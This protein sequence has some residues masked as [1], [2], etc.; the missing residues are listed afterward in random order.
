[1][2]ASDTDSVD[3]ETVEMYVRLYPYILRDFMHR[4][5]MRNLLLANF[6]QTEASSFIDFGSDVEGI[7][8]ALEYKSFLDTGEELAEKIKPIL[9]L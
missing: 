3:I 9:D 5:D 2:A 7:R 8:K 6:A 4:N 1:M